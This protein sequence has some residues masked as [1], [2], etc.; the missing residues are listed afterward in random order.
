M[1]YWACDPND[2][3]PFDLSPPAGKSVSPNVLCATALVLSTALGLTLLY[4]NPP[5][6][7]AIVTALTPA[8]AP[9]PAA[10]R[11]AETPAAPAAIQ[12]LR[13][14]ASLLD[15]TLT[16]NAPGA[17]ARS[18]PLRSSYAPLREPAA[19][20]AQAQ[21]DIPPSVAAPAQP[22]VAQTEIPQTVPQ[23]AP[24]QT[25]EAEIVPPATANPE[26]AR[27]IPMPAPRPA[28]ATTTERVLPR[29]ATEA[30]VASRPDVARPPVPVAP[31][32][33]PTA[34]TDHSGFFDKLFGGIARTGGNALA[35]ASPEDGIVGRPMTADR[36]TA[37]Y[38]ITAHTVTLPDGT[39]LEA[40]SGLGDA[41][42]NPSS[43][44]QRMRGA[45]PPN[46]YE[47]TPREAIFH[48]VRALRMTPTGGTTYGRAGLL[49]HSYML[50]GRSGESNG[51]VVFRDYAAFLAA[52]DSGQVRR[53]L[54]VAR[55][56]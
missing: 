36:Y 46:L 38:D 33:A 40:H 5:A 25:A 42:D 41:V 9:A 51:C 4:T 30:R 47:L 17:F 49:T 50:R 2:A 29:A 37:V 1:T 52:Y 8:S 28:F 12:P 48:G 31:A 32:A 16:R 26:A 56:S 22:E 19:L 43:V 24:V 39:R 3:T 34:P 27:D 18:A 54:V 15:P 44:A 14:F 10:A 35:Y 21:I 11:V 7:G 13:R 20:P 45:T 23:A 53:L 55:A 6:P